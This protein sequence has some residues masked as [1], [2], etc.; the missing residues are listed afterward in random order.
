M[1]SILWARWALIVEM[2]KGLRTFSLSRTP[3][4]KPA[5][6]VPFFTIMKPLDPNLQFIANDDLKMNETLRRVETSH[7]GYRRRGLNDHDCVT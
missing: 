4:T 3:Y 7:A 6:E 5:G 2:D 1:R